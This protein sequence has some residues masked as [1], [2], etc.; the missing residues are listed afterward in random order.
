MTSGGK[1]F[2]LPAFPD[3]DGAP[4]LA[5]RAELASPTK[6]LIEHLKAARLLVAVVAVADDIGTGGSDKSSH[7]AAVSMINAAGQKGLLAFTGIDSLAMW[8]QSARPVPVLGTQAA[9]SA[10]EDG[11]DALVIDVAGPRRYAVTGRA[12]AELALFD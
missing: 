10:L 6:S 4:N 9:Q 7:M 1:K 5:L 3:D 2:A 12:L 8:D 11:A